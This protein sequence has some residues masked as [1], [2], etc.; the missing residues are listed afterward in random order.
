MSASGLD[1]TSLAIVVPAR[2]G[3]KRLAGK[4]IRPLAGRPL[5]AYTLDAIRE[6]DL[7]A[8]A[9][10]S[11]EDPEIARVAE[12]H[13]TRVI[14]RPQELATD[15]ASTEGVL[16]HALGVFAREGITPAWV[17]TL[18]PTSPF[19]DGATIRA[20]AAEIARAP[21]LQ[22]CLMSV[23][24]DHGDY[25]LMA[26]GGRLTRL[27]PD[28]PRRQQ[29]RRPLFLENSAIYVARVAT[30]AATGSV[31]GGIVRGLPIDPLAGFDIHTESDLRMAEAI[32]TV[33]RKR[34]IT[35]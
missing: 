30:L 33:R 28:A 3:S 27:F 20:F 29:D 6:A 26:D 7:A 10:V 31:I 13:G 22:D 11:T 17:M 8:P 23:T 1:E 9:A 19:L 25:W 24:E 34:T 15:T 14:V 35:T 2:G 21:E 12:R 4:N 32:L 16:M 18:Q 5:L